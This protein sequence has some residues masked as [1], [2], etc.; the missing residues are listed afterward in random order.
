MSRA[1]DTHIPTSRCRRCKS[2]HAE[3]AAETLACPSGG[4]TWLT[5]SD[6]GRASTSFTIAEVALLNELLLGV[7]LR[8][9]LSLLTRRL[10]F[11]AIS[12]KVKTLA[13]R[14]RVTA[15]RAPLATPPRTVERRVL[16]ALIARHGSFTSEELAAELDVKKGTVSSVLSRLKQRGVVR[17]VKHGVWCKEAPGVAAQ[18]GRAA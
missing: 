6:R 11:V 14:A 1:P 4:K 5:H 15:E 17:G 8:K 13:E 12:R 9:D 2:P 16:H 10:E 3:H 7:T 18:K